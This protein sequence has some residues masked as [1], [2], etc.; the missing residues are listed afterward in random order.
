MVREFGELGGRLLVIYD[1][2]CGFCNRSVRWLLRRDRLDSLRFAPSESPRI[3]ALLA[4]HGFAGPGV[5]AEPGSIPD[6]LLVVRDASGPMEELLIR[7]DGVAAL[8]AQLPQPWPIIGAMLRVIPRALRDLGYRLIA[9]L[10]YH[11]AGRLESCPVP[12][13][14]ERARFL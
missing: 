8:L 14:A 10:R 3:A 13:P 12:T 11:I 1:G 6:T 9:R 5:N 7:S 2:Q 4:R